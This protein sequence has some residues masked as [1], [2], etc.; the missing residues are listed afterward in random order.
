MTEESQKL[1]RDF[2]QRNRVVFR[3][4]TP[5]EAKVIQQRLF[6]MGFSW[7]AKS[8]EIKHVAECVATGVLLEEGVVYYNPDCRQPHI[9]CDVAQ[10]DENYK[11]FEEKVME[12]F[13]AQ[14]ERQKRIEEKLDRIL[15]EIGPQTIDKPGP[16]SS[17]PKKPPQLSF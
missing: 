7:S 13:N 2:L 12:L 14:A 4:K 5:E 8:R 16:F 17:L 3:P 15:A 9:S 11:P 10:L 1:T 6:D